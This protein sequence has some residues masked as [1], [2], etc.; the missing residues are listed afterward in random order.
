[1]ELIESVDNYH[2]G[3]AEIAKMAGCFWINAFAAPDYDGE[4]V[5]VDEKPRCFGDYSFPYLNTHGE[6]TDYFDCDEH[7]S[8]CETCKEKTG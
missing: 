3:F 8:H 6:H 1:M 4:L 5:E 2:V 7:C